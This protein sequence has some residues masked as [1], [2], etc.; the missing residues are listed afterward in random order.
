MLA[1][2]DKARIRAE[3]AFRLEVRQELESSAPPPARRQRLGA[4]LNS[5]FGL[6]VLSSIVLTGLT[7][8]YTYYQNERGERNKKT[9]TERR[10]DIEISSRMSAALARLRVDKAAIQQGTPYR[11]A[12]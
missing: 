3:E 12:D 1:E 2:D 9:E 4:W 11:P 10:L 7:T 8:A 6:W 5:S